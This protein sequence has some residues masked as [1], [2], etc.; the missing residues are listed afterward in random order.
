MGR[1]APLRVEGSRTALAPLVDLGAGI[2]R[3][4][5]GFRF[6]EGPIWA[7]EAGALLFT[8]IPADRIYRLDSA[9]R[10]TVEYEPSG[11]AN[12]MTMDG[13]GRLVACEHGPRRVTRRGSDGALSV[14]ASSY[15]GRRLNSPN[16][17]VVAGDG[18]IWFSDPPYGIRPEEQE[19]PFQGVFRLSP[20]GV[21]SLVLKDF[22]RPNGVAFSPD[23]SRLYVADSSDRRHLRCFPVTPDGHL[24]RGSVF[25]DMRGPVPGVPDGLTVDQHGN[26]YSTGPGGIWVIDPTGGHVGTILIPETA[27]NC[28]WGDDDRCGL[29]VTA[30]TSVYRLRAKVPGPPPAGTCHEPS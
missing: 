28:T 27:S 8:D 18:A 23:G 10:V 3:V 1:P 7:P 22:D 15:E 5:S 6:T 11:H 25:I 17:V 4:A 13:F 21:L 24:G 30:T 29:Y 19:L 14:L 26:V 12:G 9:G 2:S 20:E 16:D